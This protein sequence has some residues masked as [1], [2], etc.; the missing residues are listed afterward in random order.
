MEEAGAIIVAPHVGA[1]IETVKIALTNL[2][3]I[4]APHVGA[5]IETLEERLKDEESNRS[6]PTWA[7]GL[8]LGVVVQRDASQGGRAPRGRVD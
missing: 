8:K 7:R 4:V 3:L 5:W 2:K 1:W 6:R